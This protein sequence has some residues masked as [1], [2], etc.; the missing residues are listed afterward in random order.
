MVLLIL[1]R[2]CCFISVGCFTKLSIITNRIKL[3]SRRE[4]ISLRACD[5]DLTKFWLSFSVADR[6]SEGYDRPHYDN[7][8]TWVI[9]FQVPIRIIGQQPVREQ[10]KVLLQ[11]SFFTVSVL[12]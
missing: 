7:K 9:S 2:D 12:L 8:L 6:I 1:A 3:T 10:I 11:N 5:Y 4:D